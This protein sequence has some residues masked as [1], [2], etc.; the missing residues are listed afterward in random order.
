[1]GILPPLANVPV[2]RNLLKDALVELNL[3]TLRQAS[4][5]RDALLIDYDEQHWQLTHRLKIP[6]FGGP[7]QALDPQALCQPSDGDPLGVTLR[8]TKALLGKLKTMAQSG[9]ALSALEKDLDSFQS[10][11]AKV[12]LTEL[13]RRKGL[14]LA[15]SLLRRSISFTNPLL[16]FD[17]IM[18]VARGVSGGS[19][20]WGLRGAGDRDG[21]HFQTQYFGFNAIPGGGGSSLSR[22][23]RPVLKS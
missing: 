16:D 9:S 18:F 22:I 10:I 23:S 20:A 4:D 7:D 11:A 12:P 3:P 13:N 8:Q 14:F 1:V 15:A 2:L 6:P 5:T 19:R 17:S 21:N